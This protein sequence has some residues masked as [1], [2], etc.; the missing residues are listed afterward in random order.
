MCSVQSDFRGLFS[1]PFEDSSL[2]MEAENF[3]ALHDSDDPA[4]ENGGRDNFDK[5]RIEVDSQGTSSKDKEDTLDNEDIRHKSDIEDKN[6]IRLKE[7]DPEKDLI[8][9]DSD[10]EIEDLNG[11]PVLIAAGYGLENNGIDSF[12]NDP[13]QAGSQSVTL[14]DKDMKTT[15]ENLISN[16]DGAQREDGTCKL[17]AIQEKDLADNSSLLQVNVNLTDTTAV[18]EASKT[19]FGCE[20]GRVAVQ[21]KISIRTKKIEGCCILCLVNY[22]E[23]FFCNLQLYPV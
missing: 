20:I 10:M 15:S 21:D 22:S 14:A 13:R 16:M 11:V 12:S 9:V 19:T 5:E 2:L 8:N 18:A 4:S 23:V 7:A 3:I 6:R 1:L 17:K